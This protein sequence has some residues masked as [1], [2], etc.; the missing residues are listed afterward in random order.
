MLFVDFVNFHNVIVYI[1]IHST[2]LKVVS[3]VKTNLLVLTR[4]NA[5]LGIRNYT[6]ACIQLLRVKVRSVVRN[7]T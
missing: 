4:F 1:P 2:T 7:F 3:V 6:Q 5:L